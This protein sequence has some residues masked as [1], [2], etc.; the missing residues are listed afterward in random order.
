MSDA[1]PGARYR[2][3]G[4]AVTGTAAETVITPGDGSYLEITGVSICTD[5]GSPSTFSMHWI[6][7]SDRECPA[8]GWI[9]VYEATVPAAGHLRYEMLPLHL[10]PGDS[11]TI[12]GEANLVVT[13]TALESSRNVGIG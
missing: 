8:T 4:Y 1:F 13:T 3:K 12:T 10:D 11:L 2:S 9:L 7:S 5:D 6:D